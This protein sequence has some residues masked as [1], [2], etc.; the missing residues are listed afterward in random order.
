MDIDRNNE[1]MSKVRFNL[2]NEFDLRMIKLTSA[3]RWAVTRRKRELVAP[4]KVLIHRE[5]PLSSRNSEADDKVGPRFSSRCENLCYLLI[6]GSNVD[7]VRTMP[8]SLVTFTN[9]IL[10]NARLP[11]DDH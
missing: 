10:D 6:L 5:L 9:R 8:V 4:S 7:A 11:I 1:I 3:S 2:S